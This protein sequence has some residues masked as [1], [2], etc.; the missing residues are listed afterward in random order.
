MLNS[1]DPQIWSDRRRIWRLKSPRTFGINKTC[2]LGQ[3]KLTFP[4][5]LSSS[6]PVPAKSSH[7]L[8]CRSFYPT[9]DHPAM[10]IKRTP[11]SSR[12]SSTQA[13]QLKYRTSP[14]LQDKSINLHIHL[15]YITMRFINVAVFVGL[16]VSALAAPVAMPAPEADAYYTFVI[17]AN[18]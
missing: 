16:L 7:Q 2:V 10:S 18:M 14:R 9:V 8:A 6:D 1:P 13:S 15:H 17:N 4:P 11:F 12:I 3:W 5:V